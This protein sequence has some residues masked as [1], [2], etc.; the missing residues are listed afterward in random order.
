MKLQETKNNQFMITLPK[1]IVIALG[2]EKGINLN[3]KL[4]NGKLVLIK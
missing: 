2:W 4:D 1:Q 3:Y